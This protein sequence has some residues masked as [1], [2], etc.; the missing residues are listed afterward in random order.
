MRIIFLNFVRQFLYH[1]LNTSA[2]FLN[3]ELR[4]KIIKRKIEKKKKKMD[5]FAHKKSSNHAKYSL[6]GQLRN[7]LNTCY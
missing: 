2:I 1:S 5:Y 4:I 7:T 3:K 6:W